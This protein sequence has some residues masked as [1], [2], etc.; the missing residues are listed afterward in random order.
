MLVIRFAPKTVLSSTKFPASK[1]DVRA[2]NFGRISTKMY[3]LALNLLLWNI[4]SNTKLC[5]IRHQMNTNEHKNRTFQHQRSAQMTIWHLFY[6][7]FRFPTIFLRFRTIY[8]V[9]ALF[10]KSLNFRKSRCRTIFPYVFA[11][12][13]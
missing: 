5:T 10:K 2:P 12:Y 1:Q 7:F 4:H 6:M 9:F 8:H 13:T 11:L 3:V